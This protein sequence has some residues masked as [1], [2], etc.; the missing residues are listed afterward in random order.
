M[1]FLNKLFKND[2]KNNC[3]NLK[4]SEFFN[5]FNK[6]YFHCFFCKN[7]ISINYLKQSY[8][9]HCHRKDYFIQYIF[10]FV[11]NDVS[12]IYII[13]K[14]LFIEI[15]NDVFNKID[16]L[17]DE[18][19]K[20]DASIS[21]FLFKHSTKPRILNKLEIIKKLNAISLLK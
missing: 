16:Y 15:R 17:S 19:V 4:L 13:F 2:Y 5:H 3:I 21:D 6:D 10:S 12:A 20:I 14:D 9:D 8:C 1:S 7:K 11:S 18:D